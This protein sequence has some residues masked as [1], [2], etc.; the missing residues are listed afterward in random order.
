MTKTNNN[1][2]T[3]FL[4][5]FLVLLAVVS[6]IL[7]A[8]MHW[9]NFGPLVAISLFSGAV[10]QHKAYAYILPLASYF[11]S[12]VYLEIVH[13][14]G[15]YGI[16]QFFVYGAMMLVVGLG[17]FMKKANVARVLGFTL[18]GSAIFWLIS[19]FGVFASGYYGISMNGLT[20]TYLKALPFY[21]ND[22]MST[23]LFFR[24]FAGDLIFSAVLFGAYAAL[25]EAVSA[26]KAM[27]RP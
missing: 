11:I 25:K 2:R 13:Q 24:S 20:E 26:P 27:A 19:N 15:F 21:R 5:A 10:L 18:G 7:N 9:Y 17:T 14:N 1:A 22:P 3:V 23:E 6:R 4:C 16:S 12:D 8:E